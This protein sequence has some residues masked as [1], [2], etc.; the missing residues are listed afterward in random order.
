VPVDGQVVSGESEVD[1][2]LI[3]GESLPVAVGA[4]DFVSTGAINGNGALEVT[5]TRV[6]DDSMLSRIIAQVR[7]AQSSRVPI[8]RLVD[9][10]AAL[11]VPAVVAIAG[12]TFLGWIRAGTSLPVATMNAVAVL[13]IAC[14]CALGLATPA[15]LMV[16]TGAAA[17][18]G[19]LL[20]D[21]QALE[22]T[23]GVRT[24]VFDKTGTLTVGRPQIQQ[25]ESIGSDEATLLRWAASALLPSEHP[26]AR[27]VVGAAAARGLRTERPTAFRALPGRGIT[28]RVEGEELLVGNRRLMQEHGIDLG[29]WTERAEAWQADGLTLTWV[30][31]Q[32]VLAGYLGTGDPIRPGASAALGRLRQRGIEVVLLSGDSRQAAT[33]VARELGIGRVLAEVLPGD[34]AREIERLRETGRVA[35]VGDG[36]NDAP[37]LAA[38]DLGFAMSS[39]TDVAMHTAGITLMRPDPGL[40]V[41]ALD[42]ARATTRT[43]RQN[44][45]WA[46]AYNVIG[47]PLAALGWLSPALAGGAMALSSLT[48]VSNALRLRRWRPEQ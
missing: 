22:T 26:V 21:A 30:A 47:I 37:A 38:A 19:I 43:I 27:A 48:V 8:Q 18:R 29:A 15:A 20:R 42:L 2:S 35:M 31:R 5:A 41:D 23:R 9:R 34:K 36:V 12:V 1:Q 6:G 45:F 33:R 25:V 11:F 4:G 17:S 28:A 46:F 39:G 44:L 3:T 32:G 14:P 40:V 10:V 24:V 13:V 16:G 7:D